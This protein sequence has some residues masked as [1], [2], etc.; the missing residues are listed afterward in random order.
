MKEENIK[1]L[2]QDSEREPS[3]DFLMKLMVAVEQQP[4]K[5]RD[6][7]WVFLLAVLSFL[8]LAGCVLALIQRLVEQGE[9]KG[10][11]IDLSPIA[12]RVGFIVLALLIG[13]RL[14]LLGLKIQAIRTFPD[15]S[16]E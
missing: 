7:R 4:E 1:K 16:Q 10:V 11:P 12:M 13:H 15:L 6:F 8:A 5:G 9:I 2:V 3:E 14:L